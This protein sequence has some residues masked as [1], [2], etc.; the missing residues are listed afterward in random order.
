MPALSGLNSQVCELQ[1]PHYNTQM[2]GAAAPRWVRFHKSTKVL[3]EI[4]QNE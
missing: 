3:R 4:T 2:L 1:F